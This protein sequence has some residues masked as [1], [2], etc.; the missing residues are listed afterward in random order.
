MNNNLIASGTQLI[1]YLLISLSGL[2]QQDK[3]VLINKNNSWEKTIISYWTP[4]STVAITY[5]EMWINH[6]ITKDRYS[7]EIP[8]HQPLFFNF[9][10]NFKIQLVCLFPGDTL[11]FQTNVDDSLPFQ[12]GGSRPLNE[13]MFYSLLERSKLGVLSGNQELEITN[14]LNFQYVADQTQERYKARLK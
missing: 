3:I 6:Q 13:L 1:L 12:F 10:W 14:R 9:A 5:Q 8:T 2:A 7:I 11:E 4:S